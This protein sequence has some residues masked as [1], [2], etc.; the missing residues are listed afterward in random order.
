MEKQAILVISSHVV[1]GTVGNRAAA[2]ALEVLGFPVW[3]VPTVVLPWHPGHGP[4]SRILASDAEFQAL[5]RDLADT[6]FAAE[7]GTVLTGYLGSAGQVE[8][9]ARLIDTLR[10]R[11]DKLHV[12]VDPVMG[13]GGRLYVGEDQARALRDLLVPRANLIT[14]NPFELGWLTSNPAPAT[15]VEVMAARA[16]LP[17]CDL[18]CTSAP[19]ADEARTGFLLAEM[20]G[21]VFEA[22][23]P[24]LPTVP[25]GLGDLTAALFTAHRQ[26]GLGAEQALRLT[27]SSVR[28]IAEDAFEARSD[29][30]RLENEVAALTHPGADIALRRLR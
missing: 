30:L 19:L 23:H 7:L 2:F 22:S 13:D 8:A 25:N 20:Q 24:R 10:A 1:R 16:G 14:P 9:V 3:C 6:S 18:L 21:S 11:N 29:E 4:A 17:H 12:T 15:L 27:T 28:Q 5:M 26:A